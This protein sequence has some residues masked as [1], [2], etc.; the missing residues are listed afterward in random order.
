[1]LKLKKYVTEENRRIEK[2]L[3]LEIERLDPVVQPLAL[4]MVNAGGKRIR[5]LLTVLFGRM[6][7]CPEENLYPLACAIEFLHGASLMHD[8][9]LDEASTRRGSPSSHKVFGVN[10]S[11]LAGDVLLATTMLIV[12]RLGKL[13]VIDNIAQA[14]AKT[15]AGEV[16]EINNMRNPR[17]TDAEY[18]RIITGKTACLISSACAAPAI[19]AGAPQAHVDAASLFGME[20]G[21]AFQLVDDA[22]DIAPESETGKPTGGDVREG[23]MTPPLYFYTGSLGERERAVFLKKFGEGSLS[24]A[25]IAAIVDGMRR[26]RCDERTKQLAGV[27]LARA[28]AALDTL[29]SCVERDVLRDMSAYIKNRKL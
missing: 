29:P 17:L 26:L 25:E 22:L 16:E 2:A 14:A 7:S 23:K 27:H 18:M 19:L 20:L 12:V 3:V 6:F 10:R 28:A 1:M 21:R 8:D 13:E 4:H 5:P 24:D 11:V 15:A 9:I